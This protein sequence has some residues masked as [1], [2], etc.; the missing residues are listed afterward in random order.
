MKAKETMIFNFSKSNNSLSFQCKKIIEPSKL[1]IVRIIL[2]I[3][4]TSHSLFCLFCFLTINK[5]NFENIFQYD[6]VSSIEV[7]TIRLAHVTCRLTEFVTFCLRYKANLLKTKCPGLMQG[8]ERISMVF[9]V[10]LV[11]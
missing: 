8:I 2:L 10:F 3:L 1:E 5:K 4:H 6:K 11:D 9:C 7:N